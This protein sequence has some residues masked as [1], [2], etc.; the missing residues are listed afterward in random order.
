MDLMDGSRKCSKGDSMI[1]NSPKGEAMTKPCRLNA[2]VMERIILQQDW[3]ADE[4]SEWNAMGA[5]GQHETVMKFQSLVDDL[6]NDPKL[7]T[8]VLCSHL[9][10]TVPL[11]NIIK[12]EEK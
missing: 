4:V 9:L 7:L 12:D 2:S 11:G 10:K 1:C 3:Q 5:E 8:E 6:A